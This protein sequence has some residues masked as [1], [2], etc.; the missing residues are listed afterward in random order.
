M[1][2]RSGYVSASHERTYRQLICSH[3]NNL[4]GTYERIGDKEFTDIEG[5]KYCPYCGEEL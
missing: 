5:W 4:L 3:C 2:V 1:A